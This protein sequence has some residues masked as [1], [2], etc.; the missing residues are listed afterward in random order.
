[1]V[2]KIDLASPPDTDETFSHGVKML[3]LFGIMVLAAQNA[4]SAERYHLRVVSFEFKVVV[5]G[6][7]EPV[8]MVQ[9]DGTIATIEMQ[10]RGRY[11]RIGHVSKSH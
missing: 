6:Y 2:S 11:S 3:E 9:E 10:Q 4:V 7:D 1:M 5:R 8:T